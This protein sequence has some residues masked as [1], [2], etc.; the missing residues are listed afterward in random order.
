MAAERTGVPFLVIRDTKGTQHIRMLDDSKAPLTIGRVPETDVSL[1]W[2]GEVSRLHAQLEAIGSEWAII[3][4]GLS[5]NGTFLNGRRIAGRQRLIDG[6]ALQ[7]GRSYLTF[8]H[9]AQERAVS[10]V[11]PGELP[12]VDALSATRHRIL[13]A[14]CRQ[15]EGLVTPATDQQIAAEVT[16]G[17]DAVKAHLE[18][19]LPALRS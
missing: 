1:E 14:L 18:G 4:D 16:L 8:R 13:V 7:L 5:T 9:P 19:P 2:D 12:V 11:R 17:V 3:D 10:T 6:D 15:H